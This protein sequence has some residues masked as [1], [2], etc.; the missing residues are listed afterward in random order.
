[1]RILVLGAARTGVTSISGV[2]D[3]GDGGGLM[4]ADIGTLSGDG[5][6]T[7]S[8]RYGG[9]GETTADVVC[10]STNE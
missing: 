4:G 8:V 10:L 9:V 2:S 3:V 5:K 1:M 6:A 7:V